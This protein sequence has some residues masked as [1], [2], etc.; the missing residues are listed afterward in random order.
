MWPSRD[1][2]ATEVRTLVAELERLDDVDE[3]QADELFGDHRQ[4]PLFVSQVLRDN[5]VEEIG[6]G[7]DPPRSPT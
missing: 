3:E 2:D 7:P 4:N 1:S 5:G 6:A